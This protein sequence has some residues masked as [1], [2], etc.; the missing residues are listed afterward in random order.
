M[1]LFAARKPPGFAFVEFEDSRDADDA[2]RKLDG[3]L[4]VKSLSVLACC[5]LLATSYQLSVGAFKKHMLHLQATRAGGWNSPGQLTGVAAA[6][7]AVVVGAAALE[8]ATGT[9]TAE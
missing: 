2:I 9:E 8:I 7:A 3:R 1:K 4:R 5:E 6:A